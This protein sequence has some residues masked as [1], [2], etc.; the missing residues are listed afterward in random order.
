MGLCTSPRSGLAT[1]VVSG[2]CA[3][4]RSAVSVVLAS[5]AR[6]HIVAIGALGTLTWG[7]ALTGR[8][9]PL[10]AVLSACDWFVV[11]L[12]NRVVDLDEDL[13]NG[14]TGA[15][16]VARNRWRTVAVGVTVLVFSLLASAA[17]APQTLWPRLAFHVLG[18]LYNWRLLPL[19]GGRRRIK[20]L[21]F[22]KN[23]ASA[24]GFLLTCFA[25]PLLT[26]PL[27]PDVDATAVI[28][29][30]AFF[31]F[32]ELS[33]EVLYDLRDVEGDR[34]VGVKTWPVLL[35]PRGGAAI[36]VAQMLA[37]T[38]IAVIGFVAGALPWHIT[39]MGAAPL[40]Q[41]AVVGPRLPDRVNSSLCI[42]VTWLGAGLLVAYLVWEALGLPGSRG[43]L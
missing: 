23:L 2:A 33:Y 35:G 9:L 1:A 22:W 26:A 17:W 40:V 31:L 34:L 24:T 3:C 20:E 8:L 42:G 38:G 29:A 7:F 14:I 13:H 37:A 30:G 6:L 28:V 4:E 36:A 10:L 43:L 15:N 5:I 27:A 41:L 11:N 25:G 16:V 21:A 18:V 19:P 12:L 39:I 32:F